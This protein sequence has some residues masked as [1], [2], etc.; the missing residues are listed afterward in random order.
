LFSCSKLSTFIFYCINYES[1]KYNINIIG[2]GPCESR[3]DTIMEC[4]QDIIK[5]SVD[6]LT[7]TFEYD[8]TTGKQ[9]FLNY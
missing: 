4:V 3:S 9:H 6:G 5:P 1:L 8:A 2:G 7:N